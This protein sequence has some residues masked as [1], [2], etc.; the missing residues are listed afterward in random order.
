MCVRDDCKH[1]GAHILQMPENRINAG[2]SGAA[3]SKLFQSM[4][5]SIYGGN[6]LAE[7]RPSVLVEKT[8]RERNGTMQRVAG[9]RSV[10][11]PTVAFQSRKLIQLAMHLHESEAGLDAAISRRLTKPA[12]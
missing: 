10:D 8:R 3:S 4:N 12:T 1:T 11:H 9:D 7:L 2:A 6:V 5:S